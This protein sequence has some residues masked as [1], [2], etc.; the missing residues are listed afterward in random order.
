MERPADPESRSVLLLPISEPFDF[1]KKPGFAGRRK[2]FGDAAQTVGRHLGAV[3]GKIGRHGKQL[4]R[5]GIGVSSFTPSSGAGVPDSAAASIAG[6]ASAKFVI[7]R[8][9]PTGGDV[10]R[11][12]CRRRG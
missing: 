2:P 3:G 12:P 11:G 9:M 6:G 1:M 7:T 10:A 5:H 4:M 8:L